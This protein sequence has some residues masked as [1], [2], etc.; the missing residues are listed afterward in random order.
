MSE[1]LAGQG[2]QFDIRLAWPQWAAEDPKPVN[3]FV[4]SAGLPV[5][6]G[7]E[8][9]TTDPMSYIVFGHALPPL[10]P[11]RVDLTEMTGNVYEMPISV[12]STICMSFDRLV[13]LH[14]ILG[15]HIAQSKGSGTSA[16]K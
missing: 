12:Q 16:S 6:A 14:E 7:T 2:Q 8:E 10:S 15:Q 3:Q 9:T 11:P 5:R 13:E 4:I 1:D